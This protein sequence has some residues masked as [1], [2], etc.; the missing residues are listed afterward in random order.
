MIIVRQLY[1]ERK[2]EWGIF[3]M[4]DTSVPDALNRLQAILRDLDSVLIAFSGGVDSTLLAKVAHDVLGDRC[5]AVTATSDLHPPDEA[6]H[7]RRLA[8]LIGIKHMIIQ[9]PGSELPGLADNPPDRCYICKKALLTRLRELAEQLGFKHVVDGANT[10]DAGVHRPGM[11]A[12][13]ELGVR[14]PL[15][16]AGLSKPMIRAISKSLDLP[17]WNL[18]PTPSLATRFPYGEKMSA[19]MLT[20]IVKAEAY[21]R[22]LGLLEFRVR[23]HGPLA[24][25]EAHPRDFV[26]MMNDS[27]RQDLIRT[28]KTLGFHYV[29]IDLQGYR[30]GSMDETLPDKKDSR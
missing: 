23:V 21:L 8:A 19:E 26:L 13:S 22:T 12:V 30:S 14:S 20:A 6:V 2:P 16:E 3:H 18:P 28:F 27:T 7:A 4:T 5:L 24:R 25:I 17:T 9:T 15:K 11:R 29:T 1:S 10:D